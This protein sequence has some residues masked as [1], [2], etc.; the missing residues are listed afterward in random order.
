MPHLPY[1][2]AITLK[3]FAEILSPDVVTV[4]EN[5]GIK[6][7]S[8]MSIVITASY[9]IGMLLLALSANFLHFWRHL[10][11]SLAIPA[12]SLILIV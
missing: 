8:W 6:P 3:F 10:Q 7:R 4:T 12:T 1:V 11:M 2:C 9:P 5:I